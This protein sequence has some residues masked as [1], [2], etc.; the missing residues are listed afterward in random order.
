MVADV[1]AGPWDVGRATGASGFGRMEAT[2]VEDGDTA[3]R[4]MAGPRKGV[5]DGIDL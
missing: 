1:P 3:G 5:H 4:Q 2:S